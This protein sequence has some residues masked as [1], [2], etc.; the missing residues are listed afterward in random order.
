MASSNDNSNDASQWIVVETAYPTNYGCNRGRNWSRAAM[1]V[2]S[3]RSRSDGTYPSRDEAVKAARAK[4]NR[5]DFF[6]DACAPDPNDS[7]YDSEDYEGSDDSYEYQ[8][9]NTDEPP[10]D[11][12][13]LQN[14]DNDE[15]VR[16]EVMTVAEFEKQEA[17]DAAYVRRE[18]MRHQ[19]EGTVEHVMLGMQIKDAGRVFYT[20]PPSPNFIKA[21]LE[22]FDYEVEDDGETEKKGNYAPKKVDIPPNAS[23]IKSLMYKGGNAFDKYTRKF[24]LEKIS[25]ETEDAKAEDFE[26]SGLLCILKACTSLEELHIQCTNF[27][28]FIS[29]VLL[30]K[31]Q[32]AAPHLAR[33]L[34]VLSI[35]GPLQL[36][37]DA[38]AWISDF[39]SLERLD[40]SDAFSAEFYQD[41]YDYDCDHKTMS[42]PYD[43]QMME[44][45]RSLTHLK[46]LDLGCGDGE[47]QRHLFN[48]MLGRPREIELW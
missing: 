37:P 28:T 38:L 15:E 35:R 41:N 11:S 3:D 23:S 1:I 47:S 26:A 14:W 10:W 19:Y 33:T 43:D 31:M 24:R 21:E 7:D 39:K 48:Y 42:R 16:F 34:K 30:L 6:T 8:F 20:Q 29:P 18:R 25:E 9:S 36:E 27:N 40:I 22:I 12:A 5:N 13:D 17:D 44:C 45:I 46:R 2:R 32:T 4:R